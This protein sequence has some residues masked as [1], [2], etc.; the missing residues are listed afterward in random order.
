MKI[1]LKVKVF[2]WLVL[3]K[4]IPTRDRLI[5]QG[6]VKDPTCVLCGAD[7]ESVDDLF[8]RCVFGKFILVIGAED[9]HSQDLRDDANRVWDRWTDR[10]DLQMKQIRLP[11]LAGCWWVTWKIRNDNI[12]RNIVS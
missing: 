4:R 7:E 10:M 9:I 6:W 5:K 8:A 11:E 3:K 1:P 12:F 2:I